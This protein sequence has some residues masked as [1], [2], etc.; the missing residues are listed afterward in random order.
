MRRRFDDAYEGY[1]PEE[2]HRRGIKCPECGS[3]CNAEDPW[4]PDCG[5]SLEDLEDAPDACEIDDCYSDSK[6]TDG[7]AYEFGYYDDDGEE[8]DQDR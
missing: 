7:D 1:V 2:K 8:D 6:T 5:A 3:M 4:C